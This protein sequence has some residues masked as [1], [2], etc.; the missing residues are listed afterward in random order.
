MIRKAPGKSEPQTKKTTTSGSPELVL[1]SREKAFIRE[2]RSNTTTVDADALPPPPVAS[3]D[4]NTYASI[5]GSVAAS[6]DEQAYASILGP[7]STFSRVHAHCLGVR[8]LKPHKLRQ[9]VKKELKISSNWTLGEKTHL[10]SELAKAL[11]KLSE[12]LLKNNLYQ[13]H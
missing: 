10:K 7:V 1:S 13:C 6:V 2:L 5:L 12:V 3:A 9:Q 11:S 4:E 8:N